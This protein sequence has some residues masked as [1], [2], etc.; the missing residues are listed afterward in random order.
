MKRPE[1]RLTPGAKAIRMPCGWG[2]EANLTSTEMRA[3]FKRCPNRGGGRPSDA[4]EEYYS[5]STRETLRVAAGG[6]PVPDQ[7]AW[8][9]AHPDAIRLMQPEAAEAAAGDQPVTDLDHL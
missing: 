3:H 7:I 9:D 5:P 4:V 8:I 1:E 6:P 2:C